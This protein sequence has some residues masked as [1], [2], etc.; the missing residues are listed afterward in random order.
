[1]LYSSV[2]LRKA[3]EAGAR[4]FSLSETQCASA[5]AAQTYAQGLYYGVGSPTF[6]ATPPSLPSCGYQV[7]ATVT[8]QIEAVVTNISVPLSATACFP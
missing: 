2:S 8:L 4:C 6:T 3:V 1:L 5:S 7:A